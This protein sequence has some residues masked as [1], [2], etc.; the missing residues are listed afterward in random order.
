MKDVI[1]V[2]WL[3]A[4]VFGVIGLI[5]S[6]PNSPERAGARGFLLLAIMGPFAI[7]G[8]ILGLIGGGKGR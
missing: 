1:A 5:S 6:P 8:M 7:I 3:L 2:I 4:I